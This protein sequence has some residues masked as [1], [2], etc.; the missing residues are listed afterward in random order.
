[1]YQKNTKERKTIK[2]MFNTFIPVI[3]YYH[4]LCWVS[5]KIVADF[6][7]LMSE[8]GFSVSLDLYNS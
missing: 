4:K 7:V 6:E 8:T 2:Q 1:M 5:Q 3:G